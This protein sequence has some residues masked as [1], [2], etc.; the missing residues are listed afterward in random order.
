MTSSTENP[1]NVTELTVLSRS[2]PANQI[3]IR[4]EHMEETIAAIQNE[5]G[6]ARSGLAMLT[7][8]TAQAQRMRSFEESLRN[9]REYK[10]EEILRST[11]EMKERLDRTEGERA[12]F[13]ALPVTTWQ[14]LNAKLAEHDALAKRAMRSE[15]IAKIAGVCLFAAIAALVYLR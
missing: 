2:R 7:E 9:A 4:I 13:A 8:A 11:R 1:S 15:W 14:A 6:L 5:I 10:I 3:A 12:K